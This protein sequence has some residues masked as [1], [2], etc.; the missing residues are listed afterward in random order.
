MDC[1]GAPELANTW[2]WEHYRKMD[3]FLMAQN[4]THASLTRLHP[5]SQKSMS[6]NRNW[7][8]LDATFDSVWCSMVYHRWLWFVIGHLRSWSIIKNISLLKII[9]TS[10]HT[11]THHQLIP[12]FKTEDVP[13]AKAPAPRVAPAATVRVETLQSQAA[14]P[15]GEAK[16]TKPRSEVR[17]LTHWVGLKY[18]YIYK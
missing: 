9:V 1:G 13:W 15:K 4:Q 7:P 11:V 2:A 14:E 6:R 12:G 18:I 16:D 8:I 3:C 10:I 17:N 5:K